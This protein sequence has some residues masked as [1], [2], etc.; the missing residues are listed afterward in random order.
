[1]ARQWRADLRG[2]GMAEDRIAARLA[3]SDEVLRT[4]PTLLAPFVVLDDV[5]DY[6]D[7]RRQTAERDLFVLSAGAALQN[8]QVVL[9]A[10]GFGAA[11]ISST[12]FCAPTV[13]E[14]LDLPPTWAPVG[15]LAVGVPAEP[16]AARPA[17]G[18]TDVLADR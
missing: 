8:L 7:Q 9:A 4:A 14:V 3:R 17:G 5:H 10:H 2:D 6:P 11:W 15:L 18:V 16:V 12:A 1:M 13:R